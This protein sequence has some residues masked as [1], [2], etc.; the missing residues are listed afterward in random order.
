M[1]LDWS[2]HCRYGEFHESPYI[3]KKAYEHL[4][5]STEIRQ[6]KGHD[7]R[8]LMF[9]FAEFTRLAVPAAKEALEREDQGGHSKVDD[10]Q[11]MRLE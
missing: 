9:A 8:A 11:S 3:I 10:H 5:V 2:S 7:Y 1:F 6:L 4:S